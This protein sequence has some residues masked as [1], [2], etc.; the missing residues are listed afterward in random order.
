[1]CAVPVSDLETIAEVFAI[2]KVSPSNSIVLFKSLEPATR[3]QPRITLTSPIRRTRRSSTELPPVRWPFT[4]R[5][6]RSR[7]A[8]LGWTSSISNLIGLWM[9]TSEHV[10]L[11]KGFY[12]NSRIILLIVFNPQATAT[13]IASWSPDKTRTRWYH[14]SVA[15]IPGNM[16][17]L[18]LNF[19]SFFDF[20]YKI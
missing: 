12:W 15:E 17:S 5:R 14:R 7:S 6:A 20:F 16:V 8:S 19:K 10:F 1:M 18:Q 3:F 13:R 4:N 9:V 2:L 11:V